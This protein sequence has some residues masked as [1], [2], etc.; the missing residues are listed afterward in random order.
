[1]RTPL[2]VGLA[3]TLALTTAAF[4]P[5]TPST[6]ELVLGQP[7]PVVQLAAE[8]LTSPNVEYVGTI[9]VDSPGIGG[10][11]REHAITKQK[12]FYITGAKGLTI[13]DVSDPAMPVPIGLLALP[14]A[15]NEDVSVS[16]D[17]TRLI[18]SADGAIAVP[19]LPHSVGIY[20]VDTTDPTAPELIARTEILTNS[21]HTAECADPKCEWIYASSNASIYDATKA[22]EGILVNTG[23][24]W[25]LYPNASGQLVEAGG[26]HAL[27]LD[28]AGLV[29]SDSNPRLVLDPRPHTHEGVEYGPSNPRLLAHGFRNDN[30]NP[31]L[32]H[33]NFRPESEAWV[34]RDPTVEADR[35][36]EPVN[37]SNP[38]APYKEIEALPEGSLRA[39]ELLIA[40]NE[41]NL[42]R[43]CSGAGALTTWDLRDHDKGRAPLQLH[44]FDPV[45]GTYLDGNPRANG[46]GCS[47]H[48]FTIQETPAEEASHLVTASWYEHGVRFFDVRKDTGKITE[49]GWFQPVV[50]EAGAAIWIDDEY[51]Y[52]ADYA[53]GFDILR[54]DKDAP[55]GSEEARV[56]SWAANLGVVSE[57]ASLERY[58]CRLATEES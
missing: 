42:N 44:H 58:I 15:Q 19:V 4:A 37:R 45:Q 41:S 56:A 38:A 46:L 9:P 48:W 16:E 14:H 31:T 12:L 26:R 49:I 39:G 32:Q 47:G 36:T 5:A 25:N 35:F 17:G 28:D 1:M 30:A 23:R 55:R 52:S 29:I 11:V 20:V 24:K 6:G 18:I 33:N 7:A 21:N 34:P 57:H 27:N 8:V 10:A 22:D 13:Y 50:T 40:N 53:R 2:T 51:V 3:A 54:F 43:T